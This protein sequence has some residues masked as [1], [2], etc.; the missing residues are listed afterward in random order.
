MHKHRDILLQETIEFPKPHVDD[1]IDSQAINGLRCL[2]NLLRM[3]DETFSTSSRNLRT[4]SRIMWPNDTG[5]WLVGLQTQLS[6][7]IPAD[8]RLD[9]NQ[10]PD[11]YVTL[12][13]LKAQVLLSSTP[14]HPLSSTSTEESMTL[15]YPINISHDLLQI[16]SY[17]DLLSIEIDGVGVVC[18]KASQV[19][20]QILIPSQ[21]EKIFDTTYS[22]ADVMA[23]NPIKTNTYEVGPRNY[24]STFLRYIGALRNGET[25][26]S[27]LLQAKIQDLHPTLTN[28]LGINPTLPPQP[29][30]RSSEDSSQPHPSGMSRVDSDGS[31]HGSP[32]T[33]SSSGVGPSSGMA[34]SS[35]QFS[36]TAHGSSNQ[37]TDPNLT[38]PAS[39]RD[40]VRSDGMDYPP[41]HHYLNGPYGSGI[42]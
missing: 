22:L 11:L 20:Q 9:K 39:S 38:G 8:M 14:S 19:T 5:M 6:A 12:Q 41:S 34:S 31:S 3:V 1:H 33:T 35:S 26:Y 24:L 4:S 29:S 36:T 25:K 27:G 30:T 40:S 2:Y 10:A 32:Y 28:S 23:L 13:W 7:A 15:S 42:H 17:S 18:N 37:Y 21:I 16:L